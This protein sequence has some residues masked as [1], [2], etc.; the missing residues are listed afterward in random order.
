MDTNIGKLCVKD[1]NKYFQT[2]EG[3]TIDALK[4]LKQYIETNK[5]EINEFCNR[6]DINTEQFYK[7]LFLMVYL[8]D[9]GKLTKNF[10]E[11]IKNGRHSN[12]Y[13]HSFYAMGIL[14]KLNIDDDYF[15]F[16]I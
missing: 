3:H 9:I 5:H 10:Q 13:P 8:H 1:N 16:V 15:D 2:L 11:N 12:K 4:I 7:D 14:N 6:W